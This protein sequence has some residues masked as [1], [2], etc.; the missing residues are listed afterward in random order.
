MKKKIPAV[1]MVFV[2]VLSL[3]LQAAAAQRAFDGFVWDEADL[4]TDSEEARLEADAEAIALEHGCGIYVAVV[5]YANYYDPYEYACELYDDHS[6][7]IGPQRDGLFLF[8]NMDVRE[9]ALV[10]NGDLT[11]SFFTD[12]VLDE[13]EDRFLTKFAEDR[14]MDGLQVFYS[15][16]EEAMANPVQTTDPYTPGYNHTPA[17]PSYGSENEPSNPLFRYLSYSIFIAVI[18]AALICVIM[19]VR[20]NTA[21]KQSGA[22]AY[23]LERGI[24]FTRREDRFTHRTHHRRRVSS[25]HNSHGPRHRSGGGSHHRSG[26]SRRSGGGSRRSGRSG[27][28]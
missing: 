21:R 8:L 4:L 9:Y 11:H 22:R 3:C 2:L 19:A 6:L 14:W 24:T 17:A 5:S 13:L 18:S 1:L 20:M 10:L 26:G 7:G 25:S 16:G 12:P 23:I 27:K 28:F 15:F